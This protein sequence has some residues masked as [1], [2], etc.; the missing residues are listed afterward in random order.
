M[1]AWCLSC[2]SFERADAGAR[3]PVFP[4]L[5][6]VSELASATPA[7][8][9]LSPWP[10]RLRNCPPQAPGL[11]PHCF[12][13]PLLLPSTFSIPAVAPFVQHH[14]LAAGNSVHRTRRLSARFRATEIRREESPC[15]R[16]ASHRLLLRLCP[17]SSRRRT[18][19]SRTRRLPRRGTSIPTIRDS[20]PR[21]AFVQLKGT[22]PRRVRSTSPR[23]QTPRRLRLL[24]SIASDCAVAG[25]RVVR[26]SAHPRPSRPR[27]TF[28][29]APRVMSRP[30]PTR[31][32]S[33]AAPF[34]GT[35]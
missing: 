28:V 17:I 11:V 33:L 9:P 20:N 15:S 2:P 3:R 7:P 12:T 35:L 27:R 30:C 22:S 16:L 31:S 26:Q 25:P 21:A 13:P 14:P 10:P 29:L 6:P 24:A 5:A 32:A 18:P 34:L 19:P 23:S 8:V 4:S 1:M